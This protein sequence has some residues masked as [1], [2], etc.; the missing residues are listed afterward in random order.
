MAEATTIHVGRRKEAVARVRIRPG[1][2]KILINGRDY[3]EYFP[4]ETSRALIRQP[5]EL[6]E[7]LG[8][9]D[10]LV[11]V[12]GGGLSGQAGAVRH[13]I[14]RALTEYDPELRAPLK[15]AGY[16]TRDARVVERKKYGQPGARKKYQFSKR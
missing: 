12:K 11:N 6:T 7:L 15:K 2:G 1:E 10:V 16:L 8:K 14:A 3:L 13:G 9:V 5:L 4:W